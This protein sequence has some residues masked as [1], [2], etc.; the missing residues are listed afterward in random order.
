MYEDDDL[1]YN[2][3]MFSIRIRSNLKSR[4]RIRKKIKLTIPKCNKK[5]NLT[6][7]MSNSL[8]NCLKRIN[9]YKL[10]YREISKWKL[11]VRLSKSSQFLFDFKKAS[12]IKLKNKFPNKKN[13]LVLNTSKNIFQCILEGKLHMNNCQI[14]C[15]LSW[16]RY[17]NKFSLNLNNSINFL[18]I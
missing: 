6:D 1:F 8:E 10:N 13:L 16:E 3:K 15:Y 18:H 12:V 17:P 14:G 5:N 7:L 11:L 9:K 2:D 4:T